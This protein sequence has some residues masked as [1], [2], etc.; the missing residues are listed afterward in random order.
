MIY[1]PLPEIA[2]LAERHGLGVTADPTDPATVTAQIT[3]LAADRPRLD[4]LRANVAR[5]APE[6]T[7]EREEQT[8]VAL[9]RDALGD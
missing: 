9:V 4:E 8:L 5:A 7:W 1:A 2:A 6:L 3:A